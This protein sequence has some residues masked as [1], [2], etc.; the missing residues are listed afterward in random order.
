MGVERY[1]RVTVHVCKSTGHCIGVVRPIRDKFYPA[2]PANQRQS[3][4][5]VGKGILPLYYRYIYIYMYRNRKE[6][7]IIGIAL[8]CLLEWM[9]PEEPRVQNPI[10]AVNLEREGNQQ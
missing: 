2:N 10:S 8:R 7:R 9:N 5:T 4:S 1:Q 6:T 3:L